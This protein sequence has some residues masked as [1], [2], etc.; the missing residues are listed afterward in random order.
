MGL[1]QGEGAGGW[2]GGGRGHRC[3]SG[4]ASPQSELRI[5][6]LPLPL[7]AFLQSTSQ[8]V[9][10]ASLKSRRSHVRT[11]G[12]GLV[13]DSKP[14]PHHPR[15]SSPLPA[16]QQHAGAVRPREKK[17]CR[18]NNGHLPMMHN[19]PGRPHR[20]KV[21]PLPPHLGLFCG[22]QSIYFSSNLN[23]LHGLSCQGVFVAWRRW[24][25]KGVGGRSESE[26]LGPIF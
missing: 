17:K 26:L 7:L 6:R 13:L 20:Q 14:P 10:V 12:R 8:G 1:K 24:E 18:Q 3:R 2:K 16:A 19:W 4:V 22:N 25:A 23:N 15:P 11:R 5:H 21:A 9:H